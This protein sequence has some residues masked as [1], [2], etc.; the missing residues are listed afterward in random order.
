[1]SEER[2]R[3]QSHTDTLDILRV[4]DLGHYQLDK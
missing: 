4:T 2:E 1:M 3:E